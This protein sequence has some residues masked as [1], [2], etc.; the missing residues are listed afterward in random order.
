MVFQ[1]LEEC[2]VRVLKMYKEMCIYKKS[3][4]LQINGNDETQHSGI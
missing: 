1:V 3:N 4:E 2:L